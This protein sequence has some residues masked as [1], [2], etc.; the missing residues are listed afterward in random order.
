MPKDFL[1]K[2]QTS[3]MGAKTDQVALK[4]NGQWI[5]VHTEISPQI[6]ESLLLSQGGAG[7]GLWDYEF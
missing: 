7:S 3:G 2:G 5:N 1:W 6:P 4:T